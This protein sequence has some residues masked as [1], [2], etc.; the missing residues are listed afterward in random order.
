MPTELARARGSCPPEVVL[1][2]YDV[3]FA[4]VVARLHLD[5]DQGPS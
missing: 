2:S 5:D 1:E 4:E 3:V